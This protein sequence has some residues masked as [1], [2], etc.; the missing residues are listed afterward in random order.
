MHKVHRK[1]W[2][3]TV[4]GI[5]KFPSTREGFERMNANFGKIEMFCERKEKYNGKRDT[6]KGENNATIKD[7]KIG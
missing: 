6:F 3:N 7:I 5:F 1:T 2:Q 4:L